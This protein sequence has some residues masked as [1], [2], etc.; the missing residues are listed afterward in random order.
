MSLT[1]P[2]PAARRGRQTTR[3]RRSTMT[4]T[5]VIA[6]P[7]LALGLPVASAA[8]LESPARAD[9]ASSSADSLL[10]EI[11]APRTTTADGP[12]WASTATGFASVPTEALPEGTTGG[13]GGETVHVDDLDSLA[14]QAASEAP[15]TIIVDGDIVVG[16]GDMVDVASN[17]TIVGG[18]AGGS[19]VDGGLFLDGVSNVIIRNLTFRDSFVPGDWDGKASD[20]DNDGIRLDTAS[21]V[22][23]DHN[24]FTRIG[25]GQ[26]DVRKDSTAVTASWNIFRD[27]NKTLGVGWTENYVTTITLHHNLFSNVHQRNSSLGNVAAGHVYNNLLT[28][29]SS[30]GMNARGTETELLVEANVFEH[31]RNPLIGDGR[32]HQRGNV[33]DDVWGGDPLADTGPTF[34]ASTFYDYTADRVGDVERLL[35][36]HAGPVATGHER[37]PRTIT[38][39]QDGTGDVLSLHAAVGEAA[40]ANG[41]VE[42][43]VQPGVYREIVSVWPG[44]KRL[45]IRGATGS[46][47]DVVITYDKPDIDWANT[48]TLAV[49]ADDVTLA[50]LTLENSY[51]G[52][53]GPSAA[54]ALR[55]AGDDTELD[56]VVI[57]GDA[58]FA[59]GS[60]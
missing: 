13:A 54:Y 58:Q 40:R 18:A 47:A 52:S 33:F 8:G 25:D 9:R 51:D 20:N 2:P 7:A 38:V 23:I 55:D 35:E 46:A 21:N 34:E 17:K 50:D 56:N 49:Y 36:R 44:A 53:A 43:I 26:L 39:A 32:V 29:V 16:A 30:Y 3:A 59:A 60:R 1:S 24:E 57:L 19:L 4:A 28:G 27:H 22:W 37:S 11:G 10:R 31:A 15:L 48:P 42:I 14:A 41:P 5:A 12:V 45:T 6:L